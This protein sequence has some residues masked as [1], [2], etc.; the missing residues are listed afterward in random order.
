MSEQ[1]RKAGRPF[2]PDGMRTTV[3]IRFPDEMLEEIRELVAA[4]PD[5]MG[6]TSG[7]IRRLVQEALDARKRK[8][9]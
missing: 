6:S 8:S 2:A 7:M 3:P 9:K 5:V 1:R 4:T